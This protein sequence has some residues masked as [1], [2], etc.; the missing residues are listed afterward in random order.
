MARVSERIGADLRNRTYA[1]LQQLS[2]EFFGGRR[3]GDLIARLSNDTDRLCGFLSDNLVDFATDCLMIL[4][5][6]GILA[7][8]DPVL[9]LATMATF[10]IIGWLLYHVRERLEHG[11][12]R[13]GRAWS[14]MTSVLADTLPGIR[15]V[16][17]FAQERREIERYRRAN[18]HILR[19][20]DRVNRVWTFFWPMIVLLNQFGLLVVWGVGAWRVYEGKITVG[21]LTAFLAYIARFYT[22]LESMSRMMSSTQ[23]A[24]A[25]ASRLFEILD[26]V[27]SVP[28][29]INPTRLE[30]VRGAIEFRGVGFRYG[31]RPV[32]RDVNL[33]ILPGEMIGLVGPSGSGKSTLVN[34]LCRFYDPSDGN[35]FVD[36]LDIRRLAVEEYRHH[37]GLVL[38]EP[39]LFYGTIAENISYGRPDATRPEIIAAARAAKAHEFILRQPDGYDLPRW[40]ARP[41]PLRRRGASASRSPERSCSIRRFSCSTRPPR[42]WTWRRRRRSRKRWTTSP[43]IA[44]RSPSPTV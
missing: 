22:R 11:F 8:I 34:L 15:V 25:S 33:S 26:R 42:R 20:N 39:F 3:T 28:E 1:H 2:L 29:P 24:A 10:P 31:S 21:V 5:T 14:E 13:G 7:W 44:R 30:R 19:E 38:Q 37:I 9:A 32:L 6:A 36:G 17:A 4:G 27:P 23:R 35:I 41:G 18:D 43:E 12:R 40:R 16:K